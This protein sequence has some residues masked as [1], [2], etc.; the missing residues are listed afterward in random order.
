MQAL[1]A[2]AMRRRHG[3]SQAEAIRRLE[4]QDAT[5]EVDDAIRGLLGDRDGGMWFDHDDGGRLKVAVVRR[6]RHRGLGGRSCQGP[7]CRSRVERWHRS[8]ARRLRLARAGRRAVEGR[9]RTAGSDLRRKDLIGSQR[10][11]ERSAHRHGDDGHSCRSRTTSTGGRA[12]AGPRPDATDRPADYENLRAGRPESRSHARGPGRCHCALL[13]PPGSERLTSRW[14]TTA[15][16]EIR[17][18]RRRARRLLHR[19]SEA[20]MSRP[21]GRTL[22]RRPK[23]ERQHNRARCSAHAT[24]HRSGD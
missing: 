24:W 9:R 11:R 21:V 16:D 23:R 19:L 20:S 15:L 7:P 5:H 4:F 22:G 3:V 6:D 12:G 8:R 10:G 18:R 2:E 1:A 13:L 17:A 14:Q